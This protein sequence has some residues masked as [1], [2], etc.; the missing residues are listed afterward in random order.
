VS[1]LGDEDVS[2]LDVAMHDPGIVGRVERIGDL[3][4][5][6]KQAVKIEGTCG[7]E[8][9]KRQTIEELHD[10]ESAA[11]FIPDVVNGANI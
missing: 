5:D 8:V 3:D 11:M 9:L 6:G 10:H 1:A 2:R 7:D 4:G